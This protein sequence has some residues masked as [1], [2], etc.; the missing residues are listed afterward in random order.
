MGFAEP[1]GRVPYDPP[2]S[3]TGRWWAVHSPN[4]LAGFPLRSGRKTHSCQRVVPPDSQRRAP[5]T[6]LHGHRRALGGTPA[7]PHTGQCP[8]PPSGT[9]PQCP[10][11][12]RKRPPA[13]EDDGNHVSQACA[14]VVSGNGD[15]GD[16]QHPAL[17]ERV[18]LILKSHGKLT[19]TGCA[20]GLLYCSGRKQVT[21]ETRGT[22]GAW[23]RP[24][25]SA[26][27]GTSGRN[28]RVGTQILEPGSLCARAARAVL[29]PVGREAGCWQPS[30]VE[31]R[32]RLP[33][34][35]VPAASRYLPSPS[36]GQ[37]NRKSKAREPVNTGLSLQTSPP[38]QHASKPAQD[39]FCDC[40]S[41]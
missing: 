5:L 34:H 24:H 29:G 21:H 41:S 2:S 27:Q 33:F 22:E 17:G 30:G 8:L 9:N 10:R 1:D 7:L 40:S 18:N 25:A 28:G 11:R 31:D 12:G 38:K 39:P 32:D 20:P 36:I 19:W 4:G 23:G 35:T 15:G 6:V 3:R 14:R 37:V 16:S 26:G 13:L